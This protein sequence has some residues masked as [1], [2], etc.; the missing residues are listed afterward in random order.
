MLAGAYLPISA[1]P[2]LVQ[3]AAYLL[4]YTW[5]YDLIRYYSFEGRW[6]TILPVQWEWFLIAF[7]ALVFTLLSRFFLGRAER[8]AKRSGLHII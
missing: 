1:F 3:V 7:F 8:L 5:A 6:N 2:P 4:P